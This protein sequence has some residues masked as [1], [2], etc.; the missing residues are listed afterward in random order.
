M[1]RD[2]DYFARIRA[3][4]DAAPPLTEEQRIKLTVIFKVIRG[5]WERDHARE[6]KG[7]TSK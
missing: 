6:E 1:R 3:D 5:D 2:E 4:V 7:R